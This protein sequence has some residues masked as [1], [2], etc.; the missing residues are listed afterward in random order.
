MF[1]SPQVHKAW[2]V[3]IVANCTDFENRRVFPTQ[4]RILYPPLTCTKF[5]SI[6]KKSLPL[7]QG[8]EQYGRILPHSHAMSGSVGLSPS[9][10]RR[11]GVTT[12]KGLRKSFWR[13]SA[14]LVVGQV[15][16]TAP[17]NRPH[18]VPGCY[19]CLSTL[20]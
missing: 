17:N 4:V 19:S 1:E 14:D 16:P 2:W 8:Y 20:F 6:Y 5:Q 3:R 7:P 15:A 13:E 12:L 10:K 18:P 9:R 11:R